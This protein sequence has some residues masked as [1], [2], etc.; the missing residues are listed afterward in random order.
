MRKRLW[1]CLSMAVPCLFAQEVG[2]LP[3][4]GLTDTVEPFVPEAVFAEGIPSPDSFLGFPLGARPV[5]H[6]QSLGY[7]RALAEASPR[8]V[9]QVYGQ[10]LEGRALVILCVGS[11]RRIA[12][13]NQLK[14]AHARLADPRGLAP[15]EAEQLLAEQPA[16]AW[17]GYAIHGDELSSTDAALQVAYQL[18]AGEDP[19]TRLLR[20]ELLVCIDPLQNPDGRSRFVGQ[21]EQLGGFVPNSDV[22]SLQHSG[23]WPW[24]RGNHYLFDLNRDWFS[25]VQA[26]SRARI[27][28][29]LAWHPQLVVDSHEMGALDT[30]LFNPPRA[31]FNPH[32]PDGIHQWWQTFCLDQAAALDRWGWSYYTR[33]WNEEL[34]PGYGSSWPIYSGAIAILYEQ[35]GVDGSRVLQADG[36]RLHYRETVHHQ[37]VSSLANL[38]TAA[39]HRRPLLERYLANKRRALETTGAYVFPAG[40]DQERLHGFAATLQLQGIELERLLEPVVLRGGIRAAGRTLDSV[41]LPAGSLLVRR[42]QPQGPLV[43]AILDF[44]IRL[45]NQVLA[46][47]RK[48]R[49]VDGDSRM[50]ETTGWSLALS[51]GLDHCLVDTLGEVRSQP[52]RP[53]PRVGELAAQDPAYAWLFE[54]D[55][56]GGL[57]LLRQLLEDGV[58]VWCLRKAVTVAGRSYLPGTLVIRRHANPTLEPSRLEQ[59]A[60]AQRVRIFGSDTALAEQG[61]DLGGD[62]L[63]LLEAPRA[64][65]LCGEAVSTTSFGAA[66][67]LLDARLGLRCSLL[68]AGRLRRADLSR[69]N[70]LVMPSG[71]YGRVFGEGEWRKLK[72]WVEAGGTL[73]A[74]GSALPRLTDAEDGWS[75]LRQQRQ[76]L[77]ELPDYDRRLRALQAARQ[78]VIDSLGVWEARP[79]AEAETPPLPEALSEEADSLARKLSPSGVI[80]AARIDPEHWLGFGCPP[81]MPVLLDSSFAYRTVD[82]VEVGARLA[83]ADQLRLSGLLWP[84]ARERWAGSVYLSR[85]SLGKGQL[86]LFAGDPCFRGSFRASERLLSNAVLLGPGMGSRQA[87]GW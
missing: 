50:Y 37:I 86:I 48:A 18:V 81:T 41:E 7:L 6:A 78:P 15:E 40:A 9:L 34:F 13:L 82:A 85:E 4:H 3:G 32:M 76:V 64:A 33:E 20:E 35:A 16:V 84:E 69:Y 60:E 45:D 2:P 1:L 59:L 27:P 38:Q 30:Y 74:W 8:A 29:M 26:E 21:L 17:L 65:L 72:E 49:L 19:G 44:D 62:E 22:Q 80:V 52:W 14:A 24:G 31:P 57:R 23:V 61:P 51:Y 5:S 56:Q 28:A 63:E 68:D 10:S 12:S 53:A 39:N 42:G 83:D 75:D 54:I 87:L 11:A 46:D 71:S 70:L 47:E 43:D 25:L 67:H 66:W 73:I 77:A 55:G 79:A 58:Q 36:A